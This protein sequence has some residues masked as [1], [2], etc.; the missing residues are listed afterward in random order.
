MKVTLII[1]TN[2]KILS[3]LIILLLTH[4]CKTIDIKEN[5]TQVPLN[6]IIIEENIWKIYLQPF[7]NANIF[8]NNKK[9]SYQ[10]I[11]HDKTL[12]LHFI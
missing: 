6:R 3:F 10:E 5:Y 8:I 2:Y 12:G 7:T 1:K 4:S 9:V 11:S